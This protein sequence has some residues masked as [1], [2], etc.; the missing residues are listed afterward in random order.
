MRANKLPN[1]GGSSGFV[2]CVT[3]KRAFQL[4]KRESKLLQ[5]TSSS[6]QHFFPRSTQTTAHSRKIVPYCSS[7]PRPRK[8]SISSLPSGTLLIFGGIM[9]NLVPSSMLLRPIHTRPPQRSSG[10]NQDPG[11]LTAKEDSEPLAGCLDETARGE[12]QL[13]PAQDLPTTEGVT[14]PHGGDVSGPVNTLDSEGFEKPP[15]E[16]CWPETAAEAK[17][18]SKSLPPPAKENS[19]PLLDFSPLK[20]PVFGIFTWSFLFSHLAY[21]VPTFHLVARAR[22]LGISSMDASYLVSVAGRQKKNNNLLNPFIIPMIPKTGKE[23]NTNL[24]KK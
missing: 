6:C 11:A 20:D 13:R 9:L 12:T 5:G 17:R 3:V 14:I 16:S 8:K 15:V 19:Q 22:T 7:F 2:V 18:S 24:A 10:K 1:P 23:S 4:E 21:F